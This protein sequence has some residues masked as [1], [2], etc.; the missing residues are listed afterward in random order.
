VD[1]ARRYV[2]VTP[3]MMPWWTIVP[4]PV[5]EVGI[6]RG[7]Q[8]HA[9]VPIDDEH[10]WVYYIHFDP[11][12]PIDRKA[13]DAVFGWSSLL[14]PGYVKR[15]NG[16]NLYLQDRE[17]MRTRNYSGIASGVL[18]DLAINETQ[19]PIYDRETEHLGTSD[20]AVICLRRRMLQAVRA[21]MEGHQPMGIDT[22]Y[23][24]VRGVALAMSV[25]IPWEDADVEF[26][27]QVEARLVSVSS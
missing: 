24:E 2:R 17:M 12:A 27:R 3:F 16:S 5:P 9:W 21:H 22:N 18:Q 8:A 14:A 15:A 13:V 26:L 11:Y 19:G 6:G 25:D 10:C 7:T 23:A 1:P 20:V 4:F